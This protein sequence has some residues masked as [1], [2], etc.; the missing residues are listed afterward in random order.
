MHQY[1]SRHLFLLC[2]G[3]CKQVRRIWTIGNQPVL[4]AVSG[5]PMTRRRLGTRTSWCV[6]LG[7]VFPDQRVFPHSSRLC[8]HHR[9]LSDS[10]DLTTRSVNYIARMELCLYLR[11][12]AQSC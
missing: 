3:E 2:V 7:I 11:F 10:A 1:K 12:W 8:E 4:G 6:L 9:D 5:L